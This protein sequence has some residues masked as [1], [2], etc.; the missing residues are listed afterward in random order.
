MHFQMERPTP[1]APVTSCA[2]RHKLQTAPPS[3]VASVKDHPVLLAGGDATWKGDVHCT[4]GSW[5]VINRP[6][7]AG[8]VLQIYPLLSNS[9]TD[10]V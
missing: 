8:A 9:L 2:P 10:P 6:G 5:M 7:V 4:V 1:P 3:P